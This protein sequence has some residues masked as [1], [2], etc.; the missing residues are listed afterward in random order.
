MCH[1]NCTIPIL[2]FT[3]YL[4]FNLSANDWNQQKSVYINKYEYVIIYRI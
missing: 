4:T 3:V 1:V 2:N